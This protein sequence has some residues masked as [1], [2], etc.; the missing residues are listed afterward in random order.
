MGRRPL[1]GGTVTSHAGPVVNLPPEVDGRLSFG[2]GTIVNGTE[3]VDG[4]R[5][6]DV[7]VQHVEHG[8]EAGAVPFGAAKVSWRRNRALQAR[9]RVN[10]PRQVA[11]EVFQRLRARLRSDVRE[12]GLGQRLP[13]E[14]LGLQRNELR[15]R[16]FL[17]RYRR[18]RH[19]NV[20][21][22]KQRLARVP[23]EDEG[24]A[25]LRELYDGVLRRRS[26]PDGD[27]DWRRR[28]VVVPDVVSNGL[29]VPLPFAGRRVERQ[30]RVGKEVVALPK[31]T[32]EVLGSRPGRGKHPSA[33]FVDC[34]ATPGVR[35]AVALPLDP[36]PRVVAHLP[37]AWD[38]VKRPFERPR[39]GVVRADV[40][41][42]GIVAL[43]DPRRDD[44]EVLEHGAG[45]GHL[46]DC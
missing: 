37:L 32:V 25:H 26:G 13:D 17:T 43:V 46:D 40:P 22:R 19:G 31:S 27:E 7:D 30:D 5:L 44:Q 4:R 8:I 3:P 45:R 2:P 16:G 6:V 20:S 11:A 38:G 18:A 41:G 12:I 23:I 35:A 21:H 39:H 28:I 10:R 14:R 36:L 9:R 33:R 1:A 24:E 34:H 29:I 42:R 15:R